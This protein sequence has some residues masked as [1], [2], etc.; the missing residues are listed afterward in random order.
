MIEQPTFRI[1]NGLYEILGEEGAPIIQEKWMF[2]AD[3]PADKIVTVKRG[4]FLEKSAMQNGKLHGQSLVYHGSKII[5]SCYYQKGLLHGPSESFFKNGHLSAVCNF[6]HGKKVGYSYF[7]TQKGKVSAKLF[8]HLGKQEGIAYYYYPNGS[9]KSA[10]GYKAG[11][12]DGKALF[13]SPQGQLV[14]ETL[15]AKGKKEGLDTMWDSYGIVLF[16]FLYKNGRCTR[17]A[18]EDVIAKRYN[19]V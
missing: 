14:R 2:E 12:L 9:I 10:I 5:C 17:F 3:Q 1:E 4:K 19:L 18:V 7:Y 13:Y 8:F 16:S 6:F 11:L 15:F